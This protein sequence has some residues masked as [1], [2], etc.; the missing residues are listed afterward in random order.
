MNFLQYYTIKK[1][2]WNKF[3]VN[4]YLCLID[5]YKLGYIIFFTV[6]MTESYWSNATVYI[7][8]YYIMTPT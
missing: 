7:K 5:L 2:I 4:M 6:D 1:F 8:Y 3:L